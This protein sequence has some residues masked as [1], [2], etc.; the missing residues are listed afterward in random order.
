MALAAATA[1]LQSGAGALLVLF[2][3]LLSRGLDAASGDRD[4]PSMPLVAPPFGHASQE[5]VNLFLCGR[6]VPNVFDGCMDLGEGM[7]LQ[8]V[9]ATVQV[10]A[11]CESDAAGGAAFGGGSVPSNARI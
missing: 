8:G 10:R 5:I 6:A 2:S 1:S 3:M 9:P 7:K 11:F 4:D